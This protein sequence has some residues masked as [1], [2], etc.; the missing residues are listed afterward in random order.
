MSVGG[1]GQAGRRD[2]LRS[3][4]LG[5]QQAEAATEEVGRCS[6]GEATVSLLG[7]CIHPSPWMAAQE[8]I[9]LLTG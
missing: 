9:P 3:Q 5:H 8:P 4:R 6:S 2:I 7:F 1:L